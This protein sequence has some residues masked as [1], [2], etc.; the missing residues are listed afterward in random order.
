M[1]I[2]L[3]LDRLRCIV[4]HLPAYT[5][6]TIHIAGTNGKG[7]V[8]AYLSHILSSSQSSLKVGRY[9]SP[10]LLAP[11]DCIT[12]NNVPI[13]VEVYDAASAVIDEADKTHKTKMTR[14]EL[15]TLIALHVFEEAKV[16]V[17]VVEVCMG[18]RLDATNIIPTSVILAS[19]LTSVDLDHQTFLGPTVSHI[20]KEKAGIARPG[21][22]FVIGKQKY[23]EVH[24]IVQSVVA[25][26]GGVLLP[27]VDV[28]RRSW[29]P[30][31]DGEQFSFSLRPGNL[32]EPPHQP[33]SCRLPCFGDDLNALLPLFG[34]HQL[35]NLGVALGVISSL[36]TH[37]PAELAAQICPQ[38]NLTLQSIVDGIRATRWPGRLSFHT[39][40]VPPSD[41]RSDPKKAI[42]L[43]DGAHNPASSQSLGDY[44]SYL[45]SI[46]SPRPKRL[47]LSY[48]IALSHSPPKTPAQTLLPFLPLSLKR[49]RDSPEIVTKAAL[50]RFT[51][52]EGMPWIEPVAPSELQ[53][54]VSNLVPGVETWGDDEKGGSAGDLKT[55][56]MLDALRWAV[57]GSCD[58]NLIVVVG[59]LYLV[60]D[61]YRLG[62]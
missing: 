36:L 18:G 43:V 12:I 29:D 10:H 50:L 52:P 37:A 33:I 7:S 42:V 2:D 20:A 46:L 3:T 51:L 22:P 26:S 17:A 6:P 55:E 57:S 8:S 56:Q 32:K 44:L 60:A 16:D 9:N 41:S 62:L 25:E 49:T 54:V 23:S 5:R 38:S 11:H 13:P 58:E 19:A 1:S 45:I 24:D 31:L 34:D 21:R 35:D 40:S 27:A 53:H 30:E 28:S 61:F 14:F 15:L 4:E 59:S 47:Q 39:I 48:I